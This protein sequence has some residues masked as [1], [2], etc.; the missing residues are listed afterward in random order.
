M[1]L[2]EPMSRRR[3][4]C[5]PLLVALVA[6]GCATVPGGSGADPSQNDP[7]ESFNRNVLE[8]NQAVD[9][10]VIKPVAKAYRATLPEVVRDRVR[11]FVDNLREPLIFA[12]DLLQ[13]R[14]EAA[15]ITGRRFLINSTWGIA[16]LFDKA[17]ELGMPRQ[18]GDFGQTLYAWGVADGPFLMLPLLGPSNVRDTFGLGVDA[19][20][21]PF[22]HVGSDGTRRKVTVAVGISGGIDERSRNIESLEAIEGSSVDFYAYLRSIWRQNRQATLREAR[23]GPPEDDLVDPG[24]A[25]PD[26]KPDPAPR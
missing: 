6:G 24:A 10:A 5:L 8:V 4:S 23:E 12:N 13:G 15:G 18:S 7:F 22:G 17:A 16:G 2:K 20:A 3:L 11:S 14:G 26:P 21:S 9:R 19:Y 1:T 25:K